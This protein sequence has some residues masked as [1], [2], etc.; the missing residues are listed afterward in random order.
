MP[1]SS[2]YEI[3][4]DASLFTPAQL[5]PTAVGRLGFQAGTRWLRDHVCSHRTLVAEHRVGLV[6]WAWQLEYGQPLRFPDADDA[7]VEVRAR[8]RG[9]RASQLEAEMTVTG[10]AGVAVR[11]RAA[12]V[13][14]RLTGDQALSGAPTVLP[15]ALVA[16]FR[17]D[18]RERSPYR[19]AVP[20]L[21]AAF[22]RDGERIASGTATF[23]VHRHHCEVADQ[24]YWA[25]TLGF[26][27]GA[28][29]E[30]VMRHGRTAPELRRALTD[31]V[32]RVDVTW[33]RAGQLW[34]LLEV[35]T[36]AYRHGPDIAFVHE[37]HLADDEGGGSAAG[38]GG[39][40]GAAAPYAVVVE[41]A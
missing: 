22:A 25:E 29:E 26:A 21:R 36:T 41:R 15:D 35:R 2:A 4:L 14:L 27:G 9:P 19:S 3:V 18:E 8:V 33:L 32:R 37:L 28:R 16:A 40:R 11:T 24:W 30:F 31:G 1:R 6:L 23:R 10:P 7:L 38:G 34:D 12:S 39:G 13:P 20:A 5:Q 17:D